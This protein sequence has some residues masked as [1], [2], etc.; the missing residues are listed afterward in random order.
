M[1]YI[2]ETPKGFLVNGLKHY[3]RG[4]SRLQATYDHAIWAAKWF[5]S[6]QP[7]FP[8][9]KPPIA[10]NRRFPTPRPFMPQIW[11][12]DMASRISK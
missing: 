11:G 4:I 1:Y 9:L 7:K 3:A 12:S 6:R 10:L 5:L 8:R 2:T